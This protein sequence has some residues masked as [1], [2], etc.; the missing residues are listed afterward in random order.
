[1]APEDADL[2]A[3][4]GVDPAEDFLEQVVEELVLGEGR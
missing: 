2:A 3:G 1:V 4:V